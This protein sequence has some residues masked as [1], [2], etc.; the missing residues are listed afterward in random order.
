MINKI[1]DRIINGVWRYGRVFRAINKSSG[2]SEQELQIMT[3]MDFI[4]LNRIEGD[5]LEFGVFEGKNFI[6]AFHF[7]NRRENNMRFF[8]F[9]S[10]EGLPELE[11]LDKGSKQF[12]KG[13]YYCGLE[14]FKKLITKKKVDLNKTIIVMGWFKDVL[15]K[16]LKKKYNMNKAAYVFID[17]DLYE[18]T[19]PVLEFITDMVQDGTIIVLDDYYCANG[20]PKK[21]QRKAFEDWIKKNKFIATQYKKYYWHGDSFIINKK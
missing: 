13:K 11:G 12:Y 14:K 7:A 18:S 5:Y 8:A 3:C 2:Y 17:C 15:N 16:E 10:F 6:S 19:V 4:A 9:D 21:G 20:S 1:Y